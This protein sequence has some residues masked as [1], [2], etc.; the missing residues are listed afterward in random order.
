M[1]GHVAQPCVVAVSL[2]VSREGPLN[3]RVEGAFQNDTHQCQY[4]HSRM[5]SKKSLLPG[6]QCP[7]GVSG[8]SHLSRRVSMI[9]AGAFWV[10]SSVLGLGVYNL[11]HMSFKR[12]VSVSYTTPAHLKIS[13]AGFQSRMFWDFIFL[14]TKPWVGESKA[15]LRLLLLGNAACPTHLI[16]FPSLYL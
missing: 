7:E 1:T 10:T 16:V 12:R 11:F 4:Q 6:S 2:L 9:K 3:I 5:R 13:P 14:G 8:A 15:R